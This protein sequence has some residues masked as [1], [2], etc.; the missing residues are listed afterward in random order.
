MAR[1]AAFIIHLDRATDRAPQVAR[2][3]E[4]LPVTAEVLPAV[5]AR[6]ALPEEMARHDRSL[7]LA[8]PYPFALSDTEV[9]V[10]LS[11]RKAWAEIVQRGL[12]GALIVEDDVEIDAPVFQTA[13]DLALSDF[14]P[15]HYIRF[16]QK[17]RERP[18][19]VLAEDGN[20]RLIRPAEVALGMQAQLVGA[21]AAQRLLDWSVRF[22]RPV[23]T[24]LQLTW[25]TGVEMRSVWPSGVSDISHAL[26]GSTLKKRRGGM[27]RLSAEWQRYRYR[28]ALNRLARRQR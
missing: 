22:D 21:G 16:P 2:L 10:F 11:H 19:A 24:A 5:D 18:G 8:P 12:D 28:S 17:D 15:D 9:A 25:E 1:L 26:G 14:A 23:D 7:G 4:V 27:A 3:T 13:F 20:T 6:A